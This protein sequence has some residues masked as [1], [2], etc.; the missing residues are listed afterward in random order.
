MSNTRGA[1]FGKVQ[2][3]GTD[4]LLRVGGRTASK[5]LFLGTDQDTL[6]N[7]TIVQVSPEGAF[8]PGQQVIFYLTIYNGPVAEDGAYISRV[9][10]KPWWKRVS[11]EKRGPGDP[12]NNPSLPSVPTTAGNAGEGWIFPDEATY[13]SGP[14]VDA[15]PKSS[16]H[17]VNNRLVWFPVPKILDITQYQTPN[18]PPVAPDRQSD[19][20]FLDD[21]WT[22]DLQDPADA[23]YLAT[24]GTTQ[25]N[26]GRSVAFLYKSHGMAL[27]FTHQ[28]DVSGTPEDPLGLYIDLTW[29][30][31][32]EG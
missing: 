18:P 30:V 8:N 14:V 21:V 20:L 25:P 19:S 12:G 9:R 29:I 7:G 16:V 27:G 26:F 31:G 5:R 1:E 17:G 28:F 2:P 24:K 15:N 6:E 11:L 22:F 10:L 23:G 3:I 13:G 32:A 4:S